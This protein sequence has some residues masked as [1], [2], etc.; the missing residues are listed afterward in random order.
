MKNA[1]S[2][3]ICYSLSKEKN[4]VEVERVWHISCLTH[5][6]NKSHPVKAALKI[7]FAPESGCLLMCA[8]CN[9]ICS[10]P[11]ENMARGSLLL[12]LC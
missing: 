1:T 12:A 10:L 5:N 4:S 2:V 6:Q 7:D 9:T 3:L 8:G 11:G